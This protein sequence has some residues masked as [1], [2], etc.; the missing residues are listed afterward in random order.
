[1]DGEALL[2]PPPPLNGTGLYPMLSMIDRLQ[3]AALDVD[4]LGFE[5]NHLTISPA[6]K[7][8]LLRF[9]VWSSAV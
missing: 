3:L 6:L 9:S 5:D 1:M 8:H 7:R 2:P 4:S